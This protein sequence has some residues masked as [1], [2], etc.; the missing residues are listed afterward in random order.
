MRILITGAGGFIGSHLVEHLSNRFKIIAFLRYNSQG[1][2]Q[3]LKFLNKE[4]FKNIEIV[5]GDLRAREE[6]EKFIKKVNLVIN[7]AANISVKRSFENPEEVFF[8]NT[9]ITFNILNA[10]KKNKIPLIHFSTSEVYGNPEKLPV[11]EKDSKNALSPY[12]ASKI[13]CDEL[14]KSICNYENIPFL[15][16]RPFN[17]YGPRQSIRSLIPWIIYEILNSKVIKIGNLNTKRDF[18]Y[19]KDLAKIIEKL[20]EKE[21]FKGEEVNICSGKSYSVREIIKLL[22]EIS[23]VKKKIKELDIRKRPFKNEILELRGDNSKIS[24]ILGEIK[25]TNFKEG[26]KETFEFY[27]KTGFESPSNFSLL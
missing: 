7:L 21:Y 6:I 3:N 24:K 9:L 27:K 16:L 2:I 13:A 1:D 4:N 26:L 14:V 15:I 8:N 19:V 5:F 25:L 11:K 18:L 22:F 12:A 20:I 23:G 17:S 10:L